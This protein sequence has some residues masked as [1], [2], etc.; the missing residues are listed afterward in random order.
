MGSGMYWVKRNILTENIQKPQFAHCSQV[1]SIHVNSTS[2]RLKYQNQLK[3]AAL[4]DPL[5]PPKKW[6]GGR[7]QGVSPFIADLMGYII[8]TMA[9]Q[10]QR[11]PLAFW[12]DFGGELLVGH[13]DPAR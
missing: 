10:K 1:E 13:L 5:P 8:N 3:S 9:V 2:K 11:D 7:H 12:R 6:V 4:F